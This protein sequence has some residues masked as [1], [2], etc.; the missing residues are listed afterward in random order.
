MEEST[1]LVIDQQLSSLHPRN[2]H[3]PI[4]PKMMEK[5]RVDSSFPQ[6]TATSGSE[7]TA[8]RAGG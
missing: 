7:D 8:K 4:S 6:R 1:T 2:Q 3:V 5:G